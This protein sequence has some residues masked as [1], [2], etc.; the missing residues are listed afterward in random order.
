MTQVASTTVRQQ[1]TN[2]LRLDLIGPGEV[3]GSD[4]RVLGQSNEVLS[5]RP[6]TSYLSGFL[7]PFDADPDQKAD[8]QADE[9]DE[10]DDLSGLDDSVIP[11][12]AA[13]RVRYL[14]SSARARL[15]GSTNA[16][17]HMCSKQQ[18]CFVLGPR[19]SDE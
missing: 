15:S 2:A 10:Q 1:L 7:V 4:R 18:P 13:A 12:P 3:L 11:E 6:S 16:W 19:K 9:L 14:P 8:Q 17:R 5:K